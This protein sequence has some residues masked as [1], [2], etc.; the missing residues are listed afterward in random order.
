MR[1]LFS[2]VRMRRAVTMLRQQNRY[3]FK[4]FQSKFKEKE[5]FVVACLS[6]HEKLAIRKFY[7][8]VVQRRQRN[9]KSVHHT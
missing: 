7:V 2:S 9:P 4:R 1:K 8:L 5:K 3:Y 6:P